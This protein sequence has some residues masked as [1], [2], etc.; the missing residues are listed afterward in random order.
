MNIANPGNMA[1]R[2][3][4]VLIFVVFSV[5]LWNSTFLSIENLVHAFVKAFS[6]TFV[7]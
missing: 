6:E 5:H 4:R 3:L 7:E 1:S 2:I